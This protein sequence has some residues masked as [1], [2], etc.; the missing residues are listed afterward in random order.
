MTNR[1]F[2]AMVRTSTDAALPGVAYA[3]ALASVPSLGPRGLRAV[4][5]QTEPAQAWRSVLS[6]SPALGR[7]A[8]QVEQRGRAGQAA[9]VGGP[10]PIGA[11]QHEA[12][13]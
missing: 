7:R 2:V 4:L 3:A 12:Q 13:A 10:D 11:A 8:H 6:C 9:D 1:P 5:E